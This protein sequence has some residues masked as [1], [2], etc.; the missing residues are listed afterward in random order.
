MAGFMV[1]LLV[2]FEG[3][4]RVHEQC[5]ARVGACHKNS[6]V[7]IPLKDEWGGWGTYIYIYIYIYTVYRW[8][9]VG[10][11]GVG[12]GEVGRWGG[13]GWGVYV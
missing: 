4:K 2:G 7:G 3:G 5:L 13:G 1:A 11:G 9:V 8:G 10:G 6:S 12:R